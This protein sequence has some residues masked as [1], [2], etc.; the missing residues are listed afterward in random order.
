M[1]APLFTLIL[2]VLWQAGA[3]LLSQRLNDATV[4]DVFW[5]LSFLGVMLVSAAAAPPTDA[6]DV[7]LFGLV[8]VWAVRLSW[9]VLLRWRRA[10]HE[11]RRYAELRA[12]YG[13]AFGQKSL[14]VL[15][16]PQG[17][18]TWIASW[19]LQAG[20]AAP[21]IPFGWLDAL[22]ALLAAGGIALEAVADRQLSQFREDPHSRG[23][24]MSAGVWAWSRHPN[25]FGDA[26]M[27]WGLFLIALAGSGAWWSVPGPLVMTF[28]LLRVS[29]V[30]LTEKDIVRRRP[31][32]AD[33]MRRTSAFIPRAPRH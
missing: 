3:W 6:R 29:G 31:A 24:V 32:Y 11:D 4:A 20:L 14:F 30:A 23:K 13:T 33:Y 25:Y 12:K 7:L 15:F 1:P 28:V 18:V 19:P 8:A 21:P 9:H 16:L 22:G 17:M 5:P 27:W 2:V 26:A 10:G